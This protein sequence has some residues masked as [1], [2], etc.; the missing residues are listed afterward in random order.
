MFEVV[1]SLSMTAQSPVVDCLASS[2]DKAARLLL[3]GPFTRAPAHVLHET[4]QMEGIAMTDVTFMPRP[5]ACPIFSTRLC[6][7][8]AS[9]VAAIASGHAVSPPGPHPLFC[10]WASG[11]ENKPQTCRD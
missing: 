11:R 6:K 2:S 7:S 5:D 1:R 8:C 3:R 9:R 10:C 4:Y